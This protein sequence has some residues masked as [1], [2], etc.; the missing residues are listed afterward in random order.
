MKKAL[1]LN[2]FLILF[3]VG[4]AAQVPQVINY[5]GRV[6]V[7]STNFNGTG[8]FKFALVNTNGSTT[9]WS[10][11]GNS[12]GGSQPTNAVLLTVTN[13]LYSVLL[14]D[15]TLSNM[16]SAIPISVFNNSDVRLRVWFSDGTPKGFQLLT[17]DQRLAAA[18][19]AIM[20]AGVN[21]PQTTSAT[22]GVVLMA[23]VPFLHAYGEDG[24]Q[25]GNTFVGQYAGKNF[26]PVARHNTGSGYY[27]LASNSNGAFNTANGYNALTNVNLGNSNIGLGD[28][29]GINL[30]NGSNNIDIG[31]QGVAD[32][33]NII[34]IG[35]GSTQT[36]TY[37]TGIV[38]GNGSGLTGITSSGLAAGSVTGTQIVSGAVGSTQL[39]SGLTLAGATT[40]SGD[41]N[42]SATT[43]SSTGVLNVGGAAFIHDYG[44]GGLSAGNTFIG[45]G[46]GNFS[47]IGVQNTANGYQSLS[48]LTNGAENTATGYEALMTND[49]GNFNTADGYNALQANNS[50]VNNTAVGANS[51]LKNTSGGNNTAAGF[52]ALNQNTTGADNVAVG[53]DALLGNINA[54]ENV[55]VGSGALFTQSFNNGGTAWNSQ[56]VAVGYQALNKNQPTGSATG[57]QNV[58]VGAFALDSN[59]SG[60]LNTAVGQSALNNNITGTANIALGGLAGTFTTGSNNIDIG[61]NGA[62]GES[63]IIRIGTSGI[64]T[65]M[66]LAGNVHGSAGADFDGVVG[67]YDGG[68]RTL[69]GGMVSEVNAQLVEFGINDS[70]QN[71]FGGSYNSASPG[72]YFRVDTRGYPLFQFAGRP[73]GST[74]S[75][76]DLLDITAAGNVGIGTSNP[77]QALLVV[78]GSANNTLSN[79]GYLSTSG[80]GTIS[81]SGGN[82][83]YS[84][85]ASARIAATEVDAYSDERIKSIIGP[86]NPAADLQTLLGLRVTDYTYKDTVAKGNQP[87]KKVVAQQVETVYPQAV[88][89]ITDVVPDIFQKAAI[90]NGWIALKTDLKTGERVR[91]IASA[92]EGI[93]DVLEVAADGTSF[94][95]DFTPAGYEVFVYGREVKDFR[96][97]DYDAISMLNVSATQELARQLSAAEQENAAL[98]QRVTELEA[99]EKDR[100]A[101][102][103][104]L[105]QQIR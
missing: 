5:Q 51:L 64:Q 62:G 29:A 16:T 47:L 105:E 18:G 42:L 9:Y 23:G 46:S 73:A 20:A 3:A 58:A 65:D 97:V 95:T 53:Y 63:N 38:H 75:T 100:D 11:D 34:R 39:A 96:T 61:N 15:T 82:Q 17:P 31:N 13:G 56:N 70:S 36:D 49:Q 55:A 69:Y 30:V 50:G 25:S 4:A 24:A 57:N 37:L 40:F 83:P 60:K 94:R 80:A 74:G 68:T 89:R 101:R 22:N 21:L 99:N 71:R 43:S 59:T 35:D 72:G 45:S 81:G 48:H 91:L 84:I 93:Y 1:L 92:S 85:Y 14:G 32:E 28:S 54:G 102:L 79:Y 41:L 104:R 19:Y 88:S 86:S 76:T 87:E 98:K 52:A 12:S 66:Y 33:S 90:A 8:S 26:Q 44:A 78:S 2:W 10:N 27:A 77:T 7:G 6:V 67:V 103:A